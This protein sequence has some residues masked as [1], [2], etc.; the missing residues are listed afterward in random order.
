MKNW[1]GEYEP[2]AKAFSK[3]GDVEA[4]DK[5][6]HNYGDGHHAGEVEQMFEENY[7]DKEITRLILEE[8][9]QHGRMPKVNKNWWKTIM[10][11]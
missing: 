7:I 2:V 1:N 10:R 8:A 5:I 9:W 4:I 3:M 11:G 6:F